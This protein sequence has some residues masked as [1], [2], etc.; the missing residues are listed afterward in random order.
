MSKEIRIAAA[1]FHF[2]EYL[3]QISGHCIFN[4]GQNS[5]HQ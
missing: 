1:Q 5:K 4:V 3:F 2:W